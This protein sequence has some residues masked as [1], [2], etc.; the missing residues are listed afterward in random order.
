VSTAANTV[1]SNP[2]FERTAASALRLLAV[3]SSLRSSAAAQRERS[4]SRMVTQSSMQNLPALCLPRRAPLVPESLSRQCPRSA[5]HHRPVRVG[6]RAADA[7]RPIQAC[8]LRARLLETRCRFSGAAGCA[9]SS[10]LALM[11]TLAS[12]PSSASAHTR[13]AV[14]PSTRAVPAATPNHAFEGTAAS[15][16]RLL[17]VPSS[18][19][20]SAAPQRE[21][22]APCAP[23]ASSPCVCFRQRS[24]QAP[25]P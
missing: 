13:F 6:A 23:S 24:A 4:A 7:L 8:R 21:R 19:R 5:C 10:A 18:L 15:A 17:A 2:A 14:L 20:S 9:R 3:P 1:P 12:V 16:L 25:T 11:A 22:S